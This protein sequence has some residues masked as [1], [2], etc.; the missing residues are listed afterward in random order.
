M[1]DFFGE[2]NPQIVWANCFECQ[3]RND[4]VRLQ[5]CIGDLIGAIQDD[6]GGAG[7]RR[8]L[9]IELLKE[10]QHPL[11]V[12]LDDVES[13]WDEDECH[14]V[15]KKRF[16]ETKRKH[17]LEQLSRVVE[18]ARR[19]S[20]PTEAQQRELKASLDDV[21]PKKESIPLFTVMSAGEIISKQHANVQVAENL[22]LEIRLAFLSPV[23][24]LTDKVF[25]G[26]WESFGV[27][28]ADKSEKQQ[29]AERRS[30]ELFCD[31]LEYTSGPPERRQWEKFETVANWNQACGYTLS[32][33][34]PKDFGWFVA[35]YYLSCMDET[36]KKEFLY[37]FV[38]LRDQDDE[39]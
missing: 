36:L 20:Q 7:A 37:E 24:Q 5:K 21:K 6:Q 23:V 30:V 4:R 32:R 12:E 17:F 10:L 11:M 3:Q 13:K 18:K 26:M 16:N 34:R 25:S 39:V 38:T 28:T 19:T 15:I 22:V 31:C 1:Q 27:F 9:P 8:K 33:C 14:A 35:G 2:T 29:A